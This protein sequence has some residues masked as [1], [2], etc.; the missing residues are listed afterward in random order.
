[1]IALCF[2]SE[3]TLRN[4]D[5]ISINIEYSNKNIEIDFFLIILT[6]ITNVLIRWTF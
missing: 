5:E 3:K 6:L 1:M 4:S 2:I